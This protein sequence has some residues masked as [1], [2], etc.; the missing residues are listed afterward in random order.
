MQEGPM[1]HHSNHKGFTL[2]ELLI[3]MGI[4][5]VLTSVTIV[6]VNPSQQLEDAK[7][8]ERKM[9]ARE[10]SQ[11]SKQYLIGENSQPASDIPSGSSNAKAVCKE[12][13]T[14]ESCINL[15]TLTPEYLAAIPEDSTE[16]NVKHT[17]YSIYTDTLGNPQ[18]IALYEGGG[19][20]GGS[21]GGDSG[22]D[23]GGS[24]GGD[25]GG[26]GGCTSGGDPVVICDC[27]DLQN[28][29]NDVT[30]DYELGQDIDCSDTSEWNGG[31][32]FEPI[33]DSTTGFS[34]TLDGAG[35]VIEYLYINRPTE[36]V[37]LFEYATETAEV[38]DLGLNY[39]DIT[40][41]DG[42]ALASTFD[43]TATRV[44]AE[45]D[46]TGGQ[47][48][49]LFYVNNYYDENYSDVTDAY[50]LVNVTGS[51]DVGGISAYC[52]NNMTNVYAAGVVTYTGSPGGN[53]GGLC[54]GS[55]FGSVTN[56]YCDTEASTQSS[57]GAYGDGKTTSEMY[58]ESTYS[59][60]DFGSVW[61]IDEGNYYPTLQ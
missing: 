54:G 28:M 32:G 16:T 9:E 45:G 4:M 31:S 20:S 17:G 49:G 60:W 58:Q 7:D 53:V 1:K 40:C 23:T 51:V 39:V 47:V 24:T 37:G 56:S 29:N 5:G 30:A 59:G 55:G 19:S 44:F 11:A 12:G 18:I 34:G 61:Q 8:V 52:Y 48:G 14:D 3:G 22:G 2:I 43:G 35:Y 6:A 15:D 36:S 57:C 41:Q 10:L 50:S 33:A 13:I 21:D 42:G 27:T 25:T 26:G 46:I 38:R